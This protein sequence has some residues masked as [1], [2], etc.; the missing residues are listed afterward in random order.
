MERQHTHPRYPASW[1]LSQGSS[2]KEA[3]RVA[4]GSVKTQATCGTESHCTVMM[5]WHRRQPL[6]TP[7]LLC[8]FTHSDPTPTP[9][10]SETQQTKHAQPTLGGHTGRTHSKEV[11]DNMRVPDVSRLEGDPCSLSVHC[12]SGAVGSHGPSSMYTGSIPTRNGS[13]LLA[14][15]AAGGH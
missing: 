13:V 6:H 3:V 14:P 9:H 7:R 2:E 12:V 8:A 1:T 11:R 5:S 15:L 10:P 4:M